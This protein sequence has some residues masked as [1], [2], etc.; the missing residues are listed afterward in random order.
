MAHADSLAV[1]GKNNINSVVLDNITT[2]ESVM[3][4]TNYEKEKE[5]KFWHTIARVSYFSTKRLFDIICSLIGILIL[6]PVA[7]ATKICY[8]ISGDKESIF[9][10]QKRIGKNG[11]E[12]DFY[13]LRSMIPN[14]DKVLENLLKEDREL[15]KEYRINKKLE[16]DPR[17]TK[18]GRILRRTSL[19]E[20]PQFINVLKGDMTVIGNR[21]YLPRE[22]EDMGEY[23]DDIE[24]TKCGIVS[25][26]AVNGRSNISFYERLKIEK[27][28]SYNQS[29][30]M[31]LKIF[32][33]AFKIVLF[34]KGAK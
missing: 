21:P 16:N 13:K 30:L 20:L 26:W 12:F 33:K 31:D 17:I 4:P 22:K 5:K 2:I 29:I 18:V 25:L 27:Y 10:T 19:D 9:Y 32:L 34:K 11:K 15:A 3:V 1:E 8:I 14:A 24:K 28:Y 7:I 6:I 23:F